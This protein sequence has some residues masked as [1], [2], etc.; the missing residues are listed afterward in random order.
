MK[1]MDSLMENLNLDTLAER[2]ADLIR[3]RAGEA[4]S[5]VLQLVRK[6]ATG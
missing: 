4:M 5:K 1:N 3:T 2:V 6:K